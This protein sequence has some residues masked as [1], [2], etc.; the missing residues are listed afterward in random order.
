MKVIKQKIPEDVASKVC[1]R[2]EGKKGDNSFENDF[3]KAFL[4]LKSKVSGSMESTHNRFKTVASN[5][6]RSRKST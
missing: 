6:D 4:R 1:R 3:L 2:Y 5:C